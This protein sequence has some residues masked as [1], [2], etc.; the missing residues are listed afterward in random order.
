MLVG[1]CL[2]IR[3]WSTPH[4]VFVVLPV[5]ALILKEQSDAKN[6]LEAQGE[7]LNTS[8]LSTLP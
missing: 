2:K 7:F 5:V 3:N 4:S 8:W 6:E 1:Q